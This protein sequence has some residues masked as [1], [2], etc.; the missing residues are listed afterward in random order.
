M[1]PSDLNTD[2][3]L[4]TALEENN[5]TLD[6]VPRQHILHYIELLQEW[7]QR[8]NLT[9]H[10]KTED[11]IYKDVID[12]MLLATYLTQ[13]DDPLQIL[14]MGAG[15]GFTGIL[16]NIIRPSL[17]TTFLE[18]NRKKMNF[19]RHACR[20]IKL[21]QMGF[22]NIRAEDNPDE[23]RE[24][25]DIVVSR[26]TWPLLSYLEHAHYYV[27]NNG[28]IIYF[29][30]PQTEILQEV[31]I[32]KNEGH[33]LTLDQSH[34]FHISPQSYQRSILIYKKVSFT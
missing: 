32:E 1:T 16:L 31:S 3:V 33:R 4:Q 34:N 22:L 6:V 14:D 27:Q 24:R 19:I 17:K 8:I 26:A 2:K 21:E 29:A 5:L 20:E 18:S 11:L 28:H 13:N 10:R 15:A 9:A 12:N 25:Y 23:Q 7:N 30:G